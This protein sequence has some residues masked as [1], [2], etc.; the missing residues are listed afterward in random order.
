MKQML[1]TYFTNKTLDEFN[2]AITDL[3]ISLSKTIKLKDKLIRKVTSLFVEHFDAN[4]LLLKY[5]I[6]ISSKL[7]KAIQETLKYAIDTE[8]MIRHIYNILEEC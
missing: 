1:L 4:N 7:E 2:S 5:K 6:S 8:M 3:Y